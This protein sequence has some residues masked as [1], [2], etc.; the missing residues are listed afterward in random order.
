M[1]DY[2]IMWN[3]EIMFKNGRTIEICTDRMSE[4]WRIVQKVCIEEDTQLLSLRLR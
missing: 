4:V 1:W 3:Y 2:K